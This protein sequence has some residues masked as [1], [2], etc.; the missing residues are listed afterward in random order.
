MGTGRIQKM[1]FIDALQNRPF[2]AT[3]TSL[4]IG[5]NFA[6]GG[7]ECGFESIAI[8]IGIFYA[9]EFLRR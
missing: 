3:L 9:I 6:V 4:A 2:F 5:M 1:K 7:L 8:C